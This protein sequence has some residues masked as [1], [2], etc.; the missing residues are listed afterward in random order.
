MKELSRKMNDTKHGTELDNKILLELTI[1]RM[2]YGRYKDHLLCDLPEPYL[3]WMKRNGFPKGRLGAQLA[4]LCEIK[5][6]GLEYLLR[7]IKKI[8]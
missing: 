3:V 8:V 6:N 5:E 2:P 4:F 1:E 7:N